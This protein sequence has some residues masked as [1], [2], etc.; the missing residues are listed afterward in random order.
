MIFRLAFL[1]I[2][3]VAALLALF[4][5]TRKHWDWNSYIGSLAIAF[6]S[7][8]IIPIGMVKWVSYE[9]RLQ[10]VNSLAEIQL[11]SKSHDVMLLKG[12]PFFKLDRPEQ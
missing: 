6:I 9:N 12:A 8:L 2:L 1:A 11:G 3:I 5:F 4:F 10:A 7:L